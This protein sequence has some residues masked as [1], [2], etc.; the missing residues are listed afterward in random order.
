MSDNSTLFH[1]SNFM[2]A[3]FMCNSW[4]CNYVVCRLFMRDVKGQCLLR[5][6]TAIHNKSGGFPHRYRS[7]FLKVAPFEGT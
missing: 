7:F 1:I 3:N 4:L 2:K 5:S 6:L